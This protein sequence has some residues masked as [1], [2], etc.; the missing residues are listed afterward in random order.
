MV[1][2]LAAARFRAASDRLPARDRALLFGALR[3]DRADSK[4][5]VAATKFVELAMESPTIRA[6]FLSAAD[7]DCLLAAQFVVSALRS[8]SVSDFIY[9]ADTGETRLAVQ[10]VAVSLTTEPL[11]A[12]ALSPSGTERS[13]AVEFVAQ[14]IRVLESETGSLHAETPDL[15]SPHKAAALLGVRSPNTVKNWIRRG[16]LPRAFATPGGH[17]R[18]PRGD[19]DA[20]ARAR[21]ASAE[22]EEGLPISIPRGPADTDL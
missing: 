21:Q 15:V 13:T 1:A 6:F 8:R 22:W 17:W 2:T 20:F 14:S 9:N 7:D 4:S 3:G 19:V 5:D 18:I 16:W 10:L 12:L 11:K